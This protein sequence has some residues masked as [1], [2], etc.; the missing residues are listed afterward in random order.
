MVPSVEDKDL[1]CVI[2]LLDW[3]MIDFLLHVDSTGFSLD[4][5]TS[6]QVNFLHNW[7][8]C[9]NGTAEVF[10]KPL[11]SVSIDGLDLFNLLINFVP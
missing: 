2:L 6:N 4:H 3:Q 1:L 8:V 10:V 5:F 11:F 9:V 7:F